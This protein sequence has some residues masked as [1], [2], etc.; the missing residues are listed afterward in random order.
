MSIKAKLL[1]P[2]QSEKGRGAVANP[3]LAFETIYLEHSPFVRRSIYWMVG[4]QAIDDLVQECFVKIWQNLPKFSGT[5]SL[6]TWIYR[7][8]MN[9][10]IDHLRKQ[11]KLWHLRGESKIPIEV[12]PV[13]D[14]ALT[15]LIEKGILALPPKLRS[16]FVLYYKMELSVQEV[17]EALDLAEGT[18]KSR[19]FTARQTF[20]DFLQAHG[21][22]YEKA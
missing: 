17:A 10:A 8:A 1:S 21:V 18:V 9:A 12:A 19:L 15:Q 3:Q 11:K 6:K 7:I 13:N 16:V 14:I 5:S 4:P 22:N 20:I 2:L